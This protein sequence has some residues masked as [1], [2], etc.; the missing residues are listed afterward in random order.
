[1]FAPIARTAAL[2]VLLATGLAGCGIQQRLGFARAAPEVVL[3]F[4]ARLSKADEERQFTVRVAANGAAID[5]LRES[6]RHPATGFCL[7]N[8]GG[9]GIDWET[10][11][12][13]EWRS[14]A[15]DGDLT[16]AGT[17]TAR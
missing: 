15:D 2:G 3:P 8:F 10:D 16:F 17:C 6:V 11:A 4:R 7:L 1:M 14:V 5:D 13:G 12:T 9:S